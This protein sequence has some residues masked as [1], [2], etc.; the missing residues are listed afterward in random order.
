M[1][2]CG[3]VSS[4]KHFEKIILTPFSGQNTKMEAELLSEVS[5]F[6]VLVQTFLDV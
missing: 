1:T 2:K 4:Y 6:C 3:F 5:E